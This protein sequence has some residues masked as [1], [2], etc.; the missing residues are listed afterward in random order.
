[1][2]MLNCDDLRG[3]PYAERKAALR[4]ILRHDRGIK[5]LRA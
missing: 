2:L 1:M 3:K 5:L 4:K